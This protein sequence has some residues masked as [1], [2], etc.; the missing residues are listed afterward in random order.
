MTLNDVYAIC[1]FLGEDMTEEQAQS[2]MDQM[3]ANLSKAE[4]EMAYESL[5]GKMYY[6]LSEYRAETRDFMG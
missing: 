4:M 6:Y 1:D 3:K 2:L 5:P